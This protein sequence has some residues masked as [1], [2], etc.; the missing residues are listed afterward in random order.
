[1]FLSGHFIA[2]SC[3]EV[4]VRILCLALRRTE[5][6]SE[7]CINH[8]YKTANGKRVHKQT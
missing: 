2:E 3:T 7:E 5:I 8:G 4:I 1:V 6:L